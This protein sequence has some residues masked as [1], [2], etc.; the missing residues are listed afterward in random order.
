MDHARTAPRTGDSHAGRP[1][2]ARAVRAAGV[3]AL[4]LGLSGG[5]P[6]RPAQRPA[7]PSFVEDFR[8]FDRGTDQVRP[9]K[10][11]RWRTVFGYG[12]ALAV[13][14]RELSGTSV[15]M[16]PEFAGV[17]AGEPGPRP[18]G[19]DPFV[20]RPGEL[21]ILA[22]KTPPAA[23]PLLWNRP[24][25]S[26]SLST[27]F[28][29]SQLFGYFEVEAKLP[30]GKGMWPAF[31]LLPVTGQ[32]P[33]AGEVDVFEAL[34]DPRAIYTTAIFGKDRKA[35]QRIALPFDSSADF[36]RYGVLWA[37]DKLTW[38][39]DRKPVF[40]APTPPALKKTPMFMLLSFA[41]GGPWGGYPDAN[42]VFPGRYV[43]RRVSAWRLGEQPVG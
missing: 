22:Q 42:T 14:N 11:H 29:F 37:P 34:G 16:S 7:S 21:T 27:K 31:W 23:R 35:H 43:V 38:Y 19:L 15:A 4:L 33:E 18:L 30:R 5:A 28:S 39:V 1:R 8:T 25:Y 12:G 6:A 17:R 9:A 36:H 26:G 2:T 32:W 20:H 41:V 13:H 40:A 10:P 3:I 24:Y